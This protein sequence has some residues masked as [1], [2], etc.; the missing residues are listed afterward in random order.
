[1]CVVW[2]VHMLYVCCMWCGVMC[3]YGTHVYVV[4]MVYVW[5]LYVLCYGICMYVVCMYVLCA[6]YVVCG[7]C[8]CVIGQRSALGVFPS[9][10]SFPVLR[11]SPTKS[12]GHCC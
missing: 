2:S 7:V 11:Q 6:V 9:L 4:C 10:L 1:M 12:A 8:V 3:V 5:M